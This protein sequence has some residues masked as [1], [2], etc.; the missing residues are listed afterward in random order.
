[1]ARTANPQLKAALLEE[2]RRVVLEEGYAALSTRKIA[3]AVGCTATSIYLYFRN[4]DELVHAL[5][6]EG[7]GRLHDELIEAAETRP[8]PRDQVEAVCRA[9]LLFAIE[10]PAYYEIMFTLHPQHME[11]YPQDKYR[12]VRRNL[13][14][15]GA[16]LARAAKRTPTAADPKFLV[17]ATVLWSSLHGLAALILAERI[18]R[19]IERTALVEQGVA[20]ALQLIDLLA[21]DDSA[22]VTPASAPPASASASNSSAAISKAP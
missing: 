6:D 16:L 20:Q 14:L 4:K 18:D 15:M 5:I 7:I 22:S 2:A 11:R 21:S 17:P 1:M 19:G 9:Y 8:S 10:N 12:R 13:E 3:K